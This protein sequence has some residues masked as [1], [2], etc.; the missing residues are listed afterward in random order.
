VR[1]FAAFLV[2][3]TLF[4]VL[5]C[6]QF[7][8]SDA[9]KLSA[10]ARLAAAKVRSAMPPAVNLAAL[11]DAVRKELP[12]RLED[13]VKDRLAADRRLAG[14]DISVSAEGGAV[15]LRGVVPDARARKVAVSLAENTA[16]VEAVVDELA[17]PE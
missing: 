8:A 3:I 5:V 16:G 10:V 7:Q 6:P 14:V 11:A 13:R 9:D 4:A 17:V 1:Q 2:V 12:A 15:R